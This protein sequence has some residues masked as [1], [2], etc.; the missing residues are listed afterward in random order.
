M[1]THSAEV[2]K[3]NTIKVSHWN[4]K[5]SLWN[6]KEQLKGDCHFNSAPKRKSIIVFHKDLEYQFLIPTE[7][8]ANKIIPLQMQPLKCNHDDFTH[9]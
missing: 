6:I 2:S 3:L 5:V 7:S 9:L 4:I 1:R 8:K